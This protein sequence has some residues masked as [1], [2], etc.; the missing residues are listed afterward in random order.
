MTHHHTY[1]TR[2]YLRI[3]DELY[4][5][6]LLVGGF[7]R[8]YEI[9]RDFRNEGIDR[10]HSPE[11]T[12]LEAYQAYADYEDMMELL[13]SLVSTVAQQVLGTTRIEWDGHE[14]EL[15]PPWPRRSMSELIRDG[16]GIDI[17]K[18]GELEALRQEVRN[19]QLSDVDPQAS[20]TWGRLVDDIFSA[21]VEP[22]L[23]GPVFVVDYPVELS[24]LAKR[25]VDRPGLVERFEAYLGGMEIANAF[26]ELNDPEDQRSRFEEQAK[27]KSA[28]D[29]DAHPVD[30]EFIEALEQGMPP[31]GGIG[32]GL[33]R[34]VMLLTGA[35]SLREVELFPT[36]RTRDE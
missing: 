6:R 3:S 19:A 8:V 26:T 18:V 25:A 30:E 34:L 16:A 13:E 9:C 11:F 1:D 35:P 17:E 2:L 10:T 28:G 36:L 5:K 21:T 27:A 12:M 22:N 15:A 23:A 20:S 31:T 29:E 24:P 14:I 7:D 4:L 32:M 33:G